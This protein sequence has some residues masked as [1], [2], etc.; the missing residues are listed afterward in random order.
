MRLKKAL[1]TVVFISLGVFLFSQ[2]LSA[3][4]SGTERKKEWLP[5]GSLAPD[6]HLID[7]VSGKRISRDDLAAKKALLIIFLCRHCPYVQHDKA[8]IIQMARDYAARDVGIVAVSANDPVA[9]PED[10][11]EKLKEMAVTDG[12]PMPLLFDE[13][14]EVAK[15]YTAVA[16]PDF[17]L[18]DRDRKLVYRGQFDDSRPGGDIPV[19][20]KDVRA[21]LDAVLEGKSVPSEQKPPMGCSIKW[22][23]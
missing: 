8:G 4:P 18:F 12:F 11:P 17:F 19:T 5:L 9:Y 21:A 22:K 15:A 7:V 23:K 1:A 16:T 14:Q 13:T 10:A 20:G 2:S 6:F 3:V